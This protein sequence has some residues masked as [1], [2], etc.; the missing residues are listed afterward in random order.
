MK[1]TV[2][3]GLTNWGLVTASAGTALTAWLLVKFFNARSALRRYPA[4]RER[5]EHA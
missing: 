3:A 5:S 4:E 2:V 1:G